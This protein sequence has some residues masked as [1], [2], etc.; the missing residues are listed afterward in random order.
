LRKPW[1]SVFGVALPEEPSKILVIFAIS[2]RRGR[3]ADPMDTVVYGA[4]P[5]LGFAAY[6]KPGLSRAACRDVAGRWAALR[7]VLTVPFHGALVI[8]AG[9]YLA[10]AR[11]G[12]ALGRAPAAPRTGRASRAGCWSCSRRSDARSLPIFPC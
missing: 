7:S 1:H 12:T 6:E 3:F 8:I 5:G 10:I 2:A 4:R 9:A 11:S